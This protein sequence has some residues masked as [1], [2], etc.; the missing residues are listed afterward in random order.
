VERISQPTA[1]PWQAR[2]TSRR[3]HPTFHLATAHPG[4]YN[5]DLGVR[6]T[7]GSSKGIS[8]ST[9]GSITRWIG[10]LK[11]GD[12]AAAQELWQAYFQRL[13][14]LARA[15]LRHVPRRAAD[16]EDVALSAFDSFCRGTQR[17][18][19]PR[20]DDR[21]D[22][23]QVLVLITVR[24]AIDLA[25]HEG[26]RARS[27][28]VQ[29]FADLADP[30]IEAL[31]GVGD[32]PTPLLAAQMAD[33]CRRLLGRLDEPTLRTVALWKMEGYTNQEIADRLDCVVTTVERKLQRIRKLWEREQ[34]SGHERY[35]PDQR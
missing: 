15:R 33:E 9:Q 19:F 1:P 31:L 28:R 34:E 13:V 29:T 10:L 11:D 30:E 3:G 26:R 21:D 32:E 24:K 17:G 8:M 4:I 23:W 6:S 25:H 16:E 12:H 22:L 35:P 2:S 14:V 27:G 18:R 5:H 20:L 7:E